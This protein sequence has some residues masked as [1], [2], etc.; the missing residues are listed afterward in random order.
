MAR[1]K[2][3]APFQHLKDNGKK[4]TL[5]VHKLSFLVLMGLIG[6]CTSP[7]SPKSPPVDPPGFA[8]TALLE[9]VANN[10]IM[11]SY[12][13]FESAASTL[14]SALKEYQTAVSSSGEKATKLEL[15]RTAWKSAMVAW[16]AVEA[17]QIGPVA[18]KGKRLGGES[19]RD[20]VFSWP[21][22]NTCRV[23]QEIVYQKYSE[24][25]FFSE[26]LVMSYGLD[27]L[28]Y[29]LFVHSP[30]NT[31]N[32]LVDINRDGTW[33]QLSETDLEQRRA[34]YGHALATQLVLQ[35]KRIVSAWSSTGG[36]FIGQFTK[37]GTNNSEY[38]TAQDAINELFAALYY[39]DLVVKDSKLATPAALS[40]NCMETA[41]PEKLESRW[42]KHSRENIV[43]NLKS[44]RRT[45]V[46]GDLS[47]QEHIGFDD[48]L[49]ALGA[50]ELSENLL[51]ALDDA[52]ILIESHN[53]SYYDALAADQTDL[54]D[55]H[56]SIKKVT[57][58]LK[59]QFV[60]LLAL[61]VPQEGA[62]DND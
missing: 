26:S 10:V 11:P 44:F 1:N 61:E 17:L 14:E 2:P 58:L 51:R 13:E 39:I 54:V 52:I 48:F 5:Q 29:V 7:P 37:A 28:E 60:S 30:M 55:A 45:F 40:M 9:S 21:T 23:E 46:G 49:I 27:A 42:A 56:D 36:D 18:Q 20:E 15:A 25:T 8:R 34:D 22:V 24:S 19:I 62:A 43:A 12:L 31:C 33:A 59:T 16:Q 6:A 3:C 53:G 57:D 50:S 35:A 32:T 38:A 47:N 4:M 41:C